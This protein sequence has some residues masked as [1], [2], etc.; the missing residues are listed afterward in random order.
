MAQTSRKVSTVTR[1]V[2]A[3]SARRVSYGDCGSVQACQG[4]GARA[5]EVVLRAILGWALRR[6]ARSH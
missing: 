5:W 4:E 3:L 6:R 2:Q 1:T